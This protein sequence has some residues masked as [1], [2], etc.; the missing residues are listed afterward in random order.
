MK[1][2]SNLIRVYSG[3]NSG[4]SKKYPSLAIHPTDEE[5]KAKLEELL[6]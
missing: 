5:V 6:K 2:N 3:I 4:Y 1:E